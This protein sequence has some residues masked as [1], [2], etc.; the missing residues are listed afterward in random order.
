[1]T[2]AEF[3]EWWDGCRWDKSGEELDAWPREKLKEIAVMKELLERIEHC[4]SLWDAQATIH[5]WRGDK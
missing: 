4:T 1:M 5:A 3:M 2:D